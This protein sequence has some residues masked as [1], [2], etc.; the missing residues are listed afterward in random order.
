MGFDNIEFSWMVT[1]ALT[2]IKKTKSEMG[3]MACTMLLG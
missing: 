3:K 2:T 1:S